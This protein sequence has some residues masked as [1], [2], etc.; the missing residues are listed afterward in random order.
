MSGVALQRSRDDLGGQPLTKQMQIRRKPIADRALRIVTTINK[1][2]KS[3]KN[4]C[5]FRLVG[6]YGIAV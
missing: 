4:A 6:L 5:I 2:I 3:D 1:G